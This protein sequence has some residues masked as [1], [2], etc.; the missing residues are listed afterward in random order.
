[1]E[2]L[3][4]NDLKVR[5][6][7]EA[8]NRGDIEAIIAE[9]H[10]KVDFKVMGA[11]DIP[12]AGHYKGTNE[13]RRF[14][15]EMA[16]HIEFS[17]MEPDHFFEKS[18]DGNDIVV[19]T[20]NAKGRVLKTGKTTE[21]LWCMIYEFDD[22]NSGSNWRSFYIVR[23]CSNRSRAGLFSCFFHFLLSLL[24]YFFLFSSRGNRRTVA[25]RLSSGLINTRQQIAN[26]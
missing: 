11:P 13:V 5:E 4:H 10:P 23:N 6:M 21:S 15:S 19:V 20:G 22:D 9:M 16:K 1:M 24:F 7:Y 2:L 14:F 17:E 25:G 12:Y 8:F 3:V 26:F 18:S